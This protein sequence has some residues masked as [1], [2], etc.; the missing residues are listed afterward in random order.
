MGERQ[1]QW[2]EIFTLELRAVCRVNIEESLLEFNPVSPPVLSSIT[3]R[4][5]AIPSSL[6]ISHE[7]GAQAEKG[8]LLTVR[9]EAR[10]IC[11]GWKKVSK[12]PSPLAEW[13]GKEGKQ[14]LLQPLTPP[15]AEVIAN[16]CMMMSL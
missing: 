3:R 11:L 8:P 6:L 1:P 2:E 9:Y 10:R 14:H 7:A 16:P 5:L 13:E 12:P 15:S 4:Y